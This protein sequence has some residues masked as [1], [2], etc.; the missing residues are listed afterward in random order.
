MLLADVDGLD[1][2]IEIGPLLYKLLATV[3]APAIIGKVRCAALRCAALCVL[4]CKRARTCRVGRH[5]PAAR[6]W[7]RRRA[8]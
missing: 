4:A 2:S 6:V 7:R 1:V 3:L 5:L 8:T